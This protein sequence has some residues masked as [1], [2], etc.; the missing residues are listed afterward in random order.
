MK[1]GKRIAILGAG[2]SGIGAALLALKHGFSPWISDLKEPEPNRYTEIQSHSI[3]LITGEHPLPEL[4]SSDLIIVSPGIPP[5][6]PLIQTLMQNGKAVISEIEFASQFVPPEQIIAITGTAGKT[7]TT[8]MVTSIFTTA[9]IKAIA[10]GN[11]GYSFARAVACESAERYVVEVSSFQ[12]TYCHHFHPHIALITNIAP[13]HLD[14]HASM[15]EYIQAKWKIA[16]NMTPND[17]LILNGD[18]PILLQSL[19]QQNPKARI[20]FFTMQEKPESSAYFN[21]AT[22]EIII[23]SLHMDPKGKKL[24]KIPLKREKDKGRI[25]PYNAMGASLIASLEK[26]KDEHIKK[27]FQTFQNSPHRLE[28]VTEINGVLFINDSKATTVNAVWYAL[29]TVQAPVIWIA[30]GKDKGNDYSPLLQPVSEK[31]EALLILARDE[32]V[33]QR[34]K[35]VFHRIIPHMEE[36]RS[37]EE[38]VKRA[39]EL[40]KP[41]TTVLL[42]PACA[43][44]DYFQNYQ[45][46][47]N[48]F[49]DAVMRLKKHY[50]TD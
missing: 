42:S 6:T 2:E 34:F 31:V 3:P 26:I 21:S 18:D 25:S 17:F 1:T 7:T 11:Y 4:L 29:D 48:A 46:R 35:E 45:E 10:C 16:Q 13:N 47:G 32:S 44:F 33:R 9:G 38:A 23:K 24:T 28:V 27:S 40:A 43:S 14:W 8:T 41:G 5:T 50:E 49:K 36:V 19:Q 22:E 20:L 39:F 12:L 30:G 37:M 15:E